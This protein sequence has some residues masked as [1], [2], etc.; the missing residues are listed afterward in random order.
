VLLEVQNLTRRFGGLVA[1]SDVSFQIG[2]HEI[3]GIFG[4]N[5]SGKT[6]LLNLISG[7]M[8][9]S[10]G[11]I[12]WKSRDIR[13]W[14]PD[15]VAAI[16]VVKTF[17]NPKLFLELTV[18][19]NVAIASHLMLRHKLGARRIAELL[20]W[21]TSRRHPD[22]DARLDRVLALCR[23]DSMSDQ[24]AASLSY[25]QE[26]MLG[27]AMAMMCEPELLLL[28]EPASGLGDAEIGNLEAVLADL[29]AMRTTLCIID[30]KVDFLRRTAD[31]A[32]ALQQGVKIAEGTPDEVLRNPRVIEA[33]L[34][35]PHAHA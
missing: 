18:R 12:V 35:R 17:Q 5:G 27:V 19:E 21:R 23:L 2:E 9:P 24:L 25:G 7:I 16:G 13:G 34:G 8:Q 26:K 30:H 29:R 20:P 31:R 10:S 1:V 4:P 33:Y 15:R 32:L 22:V 28:D 14:R 11:R 6:T 3:L